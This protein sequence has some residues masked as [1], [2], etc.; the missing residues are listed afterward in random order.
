MKGGECCFCGAPFGSMSA[1][2]RHEGNCKSPRRP[3]P[4]PRKRHGP[5]SWVEIGPGTWSGLDGEGRLW[6][7]KDESWLR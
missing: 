6:V 5:D 2:Y 7:G 3:V 4:A 1:L